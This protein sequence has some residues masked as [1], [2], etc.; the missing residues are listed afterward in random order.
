MAHTT[1]D[2]NILK[3]EPLIP[4][5]ELERQLPITPK[6]AETVLEGRA[7]I[8]DILHGHDDRFLMIIG[9]CSIHDETAATEYAAKLKDLADQV[10]DKI[11]VVMRVYFEKPRTSLGWKG[12]TK[13]G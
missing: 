10:K 11:L 6:I 2:V 13:Y 9:P 1:S 12:E 5:E 7:E 3:I 4:P 8:Q